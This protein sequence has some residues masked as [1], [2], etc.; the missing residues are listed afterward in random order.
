MSTTTSV[1]I[2]AAGLQSRERRHAGDATLQTCAGS[3][4]P[5]KRSRS[6][7]STSAPKIGSARQIIGKDHHQSVDLRI[8]KSSVSRVDHRLRSCRAHAA[9]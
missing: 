1:V 3:V 9:S 7:G 6:T 5:G 8:S 2:A 4:M